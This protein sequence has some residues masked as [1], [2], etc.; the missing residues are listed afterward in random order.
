[1]N[2]ASAN[3][4]LTLVVIK[5][6]AFAPRITRRS[7]QCEAMDDPRIYRCDTDD[8]RLRRREFGFDLKVMRYLPTFGTG[9]N[10]ATRPPRF[11]P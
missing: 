6:P 5:T 4:L 3:S 10:G 7:T 11:P 9:L 1:M 8:P 2:G